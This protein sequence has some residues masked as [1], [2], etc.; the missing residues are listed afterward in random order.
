MAC[1]VG[2]SE[3]SITGQMKHTYKRWSPGIQGG[4]PYSEPHSHSIDNME[5]L[6]NM[7]LTAVSVLYIPHKLWLALAQ[8]NINDQNLLSN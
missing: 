6:S 4:D 7:F 2:E 8:I 1:S 5:P 3:R